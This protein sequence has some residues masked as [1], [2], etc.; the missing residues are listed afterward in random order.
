MSNMISAIKA[1]ESR[2]AVPYYNIAL[3][4]YLTLHTEEE[5]C[6]LF[7]WQN[8]KTVVIGKNQNAR[9]E[10]RVEHLQ[11][12]GGYL[13]RR[14]S[15]GG[16]VFHDNGNLCFSFLARKADYDVARQTGVILRALQK[17]GIP[18]EVSGRNDLTIDG[19]KFSGH[20][21]YEKGA[22]CCHHGT[23]MMDVDLEA[24]S[25]Y[26]TADPEKLRSKGVPSVRSRVVNLREYCPGLTRELL[27][28]VLFE[29]F[30]EEYGL[31]LAFGSVD[32][33]DAEEIR[34]DAEF[35]ASDEWLFGRKIPFTASFGQ[36]FSWGSCRLHFQVNAGIVREV[37]CESDAMDEAFP[38]I[39]C[40]G[41]RGC[42]FE[43][44]VLS[45]RILSLA[46]AEEASGERAENSVPGKSAKDVAPAERTG[47]SALW[48]TAG[49]LRRKM[50]EDLA[51]LLRREMM[52]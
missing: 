4:K 10:C 24:L 39:I 29:A 27:S 16:A 45:A 1:Y 43:S 18:A 19:R 49:E 30:S 38:E 14:L 51:G 34:K 9:G 40:A 21:Y 17:L 12:D 28:K 41:L 33:L 35:L 3:E 25:G 20:A 11:R 22:C 36:R 37:S 7:L 46:G 31:P 23:L 2:S 48:E 32:D 8:R 15:G 42:P 5:E 44:S 52:E 6:I 26:L 47:G 50:A 13:A